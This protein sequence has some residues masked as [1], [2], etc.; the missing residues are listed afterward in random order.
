M[1][2]ET[3]TRLGSYELISPLG[4]GGMGEVYRAR[5][6]RLG[7]SVAIK[8]LRPE[9]VAD[10]ERLRRFERE[11]RT[12]S[13]LNHPS[14]VH[15]YDI[16]MGGTAPFIAME[17]VEGETLRR[18]LEGGPLPID[19]A[20]PL[21]ATIARGLA[22]AHGAGVV[23]RDLK[24]E[25]VM[26]TCD[27][28]PKI[29][30]FGLAKLSW[31]GRGP[32]SA[33]TSTL[34]Q[35]TA[36]HA[37][38]G[39]LQYMSPEQL[40]GEAVDFR[41]DQFSFGLLLYELATGSPAF[42]RASAA[43]T[44]AAILGDDH[45]AAGIT[46]PA[47]PRLDEILDRCLAKDREQRYSCTDDLAQALEGLTVRPSPSLPG[48]RLE[49]ATGTIRR[50]AVL[51]LIDLRPEEG[52]EYW[53]DGL[54]EALITELAKIGAL[55]VTSRTSAMSFKD[56]SGNL[57]EIARELG[58]H[59]LLQGSVLRV[60]DRVRISLQL[61]DAERDEHLWAESYE[62]HF[63]DILALQG[64]V[65]RAV[66]EKV[67]VELTPQESARLG[68]AA[69]VVPE[70]HERYLRARH[71]FNRGSVEG[72][73]RGLA[74]FQELA[75]TDPTFAAAYSGIAD[76]YFALGLHGFE[77]PTTAMRAAKAAA[78]RAIEIDDQL[79]EA[80]GALSQ[81]ALLFDWDALAAERALER[82]LELN[83]SH[84]QAHAA[85]ATSH[86][87]MGREDEID[88]A[89]H[90]ALRLDPR[91]PQVLSLCS[92]L[93]YSRR[94]WDRA[95]ELAQRALQL[96]PSTLQ[97]HAYLAL[98]YKR[99]EDTAKSFIEWKA[100]IALR[101]RPETVKAMERT[102][103]R[104]GFAAALGTAARSIGRAHRITSALRALR[105]P[106]VPY[107]SPFAVAVLYGQAG[108]TGLTLDWLERC[109]RCRD[110]Q[111][112]TLAINP[113]WDDVRTESRF[114]SLVQR[115]GLSPEAG[116]QEIPM[117]SDDE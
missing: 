89:L 96:D 38:V 87:L 37:V 97:A 42:E 64:E 18:R 83:P 75:R 105:L 117:G 116:Q 92:Y 101:G 16:D 115:V 88:S 5:D 111:L 9:S 40:R 100:L 58:V 14:I 1:T 36:D 102:Y 28:D 107:V 82:T 99:K 84:A 109:F 24:P 73:R 59:A 56:R 26:I 112:A 106:K 27:G 50:I 8:V 113:H 103:D 93:E 62:R 46:W 41:S 74:G 72:W 19:E 60:E 94:R 67:R 91:S 23:H 108:E 49:S 21:A 53:A 20:L 25:N 7:R 65:A 34:D 98:C 12:A 48:S 10:P 69:L 68:N 45:G 33:S 79:A 55:R 29:L 35:I 51:P 32:V 54:T 71:D 114:Q 52:R 31:P 15:I 95:I 3:G 85:A 6:L 30:D 86:R 17:L 104:S 57:P 63:H 70:I 2:L 77:A 39:T 11:A 44:V 80:H 43:E 22:K 66:S 76:C 47:V 110:P 61:I 13:A 4:A 90:S 78:L 81:I